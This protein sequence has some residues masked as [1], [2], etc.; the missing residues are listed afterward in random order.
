MATI[1]PEQAAVPAWPATG[2][3]WSLVALLTLAYVFS[4]VDRYILGLLIEPIKADIRLTDAQI[5]LLLGPAFA[6]FYATMGVP[7][8]W[9]ADRKRRTWLVAAG[10]ALWSL[11][12]AASGLAKSFLHLFVARM[13]VGI[14]EATLSPAAM[15]MI[16]DSFPP[17]RRGK[18]VAVYSA[19]L[20]LGAG[21]ASLIGALV[22]TWAKTSEGL[23][24]PLIGAVRPWQ[25]AFIAVGLPGLLIAVGFL[26][27]GEPPRQQ[28][29]ARGAKGP[30]LGDALR[31]VGRDKG[32]FLGVVSL[33]CVMTIIAYSHGFIPSGFARRYG[34]EP[35]DYALING[36]MI[37]A[38]GPATV[39]SVG[40]LA[41]RWRKAGIA[42]APFR[43]LAAGFVAMLPVN[44]LA[45]FMP[46]PVL[47]LVFLGLGTVTIGTVTAA[48]IIVLLDITPA[49]VRGQVVALY[50]M[51]ISIAGLGLGPT[52]VGYFSTAVF[53]EGQL[54]AAIGVVPVIYGLIPLLL[55]PA[56]RRAYLRRLAG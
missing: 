47:A 22:L 12:T 9:L 55:L 40:V 7:L 5:G 44:A 45:L 19:A 33:V 49:A 56:I 18:P 41:D 2:K 14:G 25:F 24:L 39:A 35:K 16:G 36:L 34:W 8:G 20:S 37:L 26:F 10:V 50:Y 13:S 31:T 11:A 51:A 48:G 30:T 1:A 29:V 27:V 17:E 15:S 38:L 6:L 21:L 43:L 4:F 42:D 28:P 54:H 52:T 23:D 32:A 53:G 46:T 3:A